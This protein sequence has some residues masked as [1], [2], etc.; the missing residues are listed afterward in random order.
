MVKT[1]KNIYHLG[2]AL[3]GA[4]RYGFPSRRIFVIGVTG[5]KGKTSVV[6]LLSHILESAGYRTAFI[7][8]VHVKVA[9]DIRKNMTGNT[10]PGRFFIQRFLESAVETRCKFALLEVTS[11]GVAQSRHRFIDFDAAIFTS[12][13]PE[14]IESHGSFEK[15]REAKLAFFRAVSRSPKPQKYFLINRDDE[16]ASHFEK[17]AESG[18]VVLFSGEEIA[19]HYF[20]LVTHMANIAAAVTMAGELGI[21]EEKI[22]SALKSWQGVRGRMEVVQGEPF[23]IVIDYAHTPNSLRYVYE[24]VKPKS[25]KLICVLGSA[26]GG[27]DKWKRAKFGEVS[28][29][30]CDEIFLADED[31]YDENPV[32][33]LEQIAAGIPAGKIVHIVGDRKEAIREALETAKEDDAVILTGKGSES[34]IHMAQGEK[35]PWDER[36]IVEEYLKIKKGGR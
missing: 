1:L 27:R 34:Y 16:G 14:H 19:S 3:A 33:I 30:Y 36:Q 22:R 9:D 12:L 24:N 18:R 26:G 17:A 5:T 25:G 31:P 32:E 13:E 10:M 15:Y 7:S 6:E 21:S 28:G 35:I 11:Q 23:R 2:L 4:V 20:P 29:R 8:S